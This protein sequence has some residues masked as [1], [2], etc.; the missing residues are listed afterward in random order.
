MKDNGLEI[1][2]TE[3]ENKNGQMGLFTRASGKTIK[4]KGKV[5]LLILTGT[6]M[7]ENGRTTR[8][9]DTVSFYT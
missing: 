6:T 3:W 5:S 4:P 1:Y 7:K 8:Q 9:T 2:A